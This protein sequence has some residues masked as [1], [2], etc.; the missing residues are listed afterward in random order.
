M[1]M[2]V[3]DNIRGIIR[4]AEIKTK[5]QS[6]AKDAVLVGSVDSQFLSNYRFCMRENPLIVG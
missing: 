1:T 2:G 6:I 3:M 5:E 4:S